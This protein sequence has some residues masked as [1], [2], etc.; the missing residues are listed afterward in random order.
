[1]SGHSPMDSLRRV[2]PVSDAEAAAVFG[3]GRT[4]LLTQVTDLPFG[5]RRPGTR[6]TRSRRP[7]V[8]ALAVVAAAATAAGAWAAL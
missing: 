4:E 6:P 5:H 7:L 8:L 3:A 2:S 1:M